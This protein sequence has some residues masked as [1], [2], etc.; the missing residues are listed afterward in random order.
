M[1][2][3]TGWWFAP[4]NNRLDNGDGREIKIGKVHT[5]DGEIIPC[6]R[7][8]HLSI[9]AIDA[10]KYAPGPI[11]YKVRGRGVIVPHGYPVDKYACSKR[12]Y[13][14][15]GADC[16]DLLRKFA[17][18]CALDVIHLWNAP[19]VVKDYLTTGNED[20]RAAAWAAAWA[21]AG[22][23]AWAAAW[24]AAWA[25]ARDAARDAARVAARDAARVKQ[26]KTLT[27]MLT[28][29]IDGTLA[30]AGGVRDGR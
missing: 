9:R 3:V 2:Q 13:L 17:R 23:A 5:I 26:N 10:L 28:H 8:L 24:Y 15:G 19:Q 21:A 14:S 25:A 30:S 20:L 6:K 18:Q 4:A 29:A 22:A 7:G 16:T 11:V 12:E 1:K 27:K